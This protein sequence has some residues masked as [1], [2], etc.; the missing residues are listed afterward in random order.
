M[1]DCRQP[2]QKDAILQ[3]PHANGK[4]ELLT[5]VH[6]GTPAFR[7]P[8][9]LHIL[10]AQELAFADGCAFFVGVVDLDRGLWLA[11]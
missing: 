4:I 11:A 10:G 6:S 1:C 8:R 2:T 7:N 5:V 3:A 9:Q